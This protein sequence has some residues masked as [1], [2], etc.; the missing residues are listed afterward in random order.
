VNARVLRNGQAVFI[1]IVQFS[2]HRH[3][4]QRESQRPMGI[5]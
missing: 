2:S 1:G 3:L 5:C 4:A